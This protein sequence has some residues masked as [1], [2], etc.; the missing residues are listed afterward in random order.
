M[1]PQLDAVLLTG[2]ASTVTRQSDS[3]KAD[4]SAFGTGVDGRGVCLYLC[5]PLVWLSF[6]RPGS[7]QAFPVPWAVSEAYNANCCGQLPP[8]SR[9]W[10]PGLSGRAWGH[11]CSAVGDGLE[12]PCLRQA[13]HTRC[14]L[15]CA[16]LPFGAR[17][18]ASAAFV[19]WAACAWW[20][21]QRVQGRW[22]WARAVH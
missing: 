1:R 6:P 21:C 15:V 8:S 11:P 12:I 19:V 20:G 10:W 14:P 9:C 7:F 2:T 3:G 22:H 5:V 13:R 4:F 18:R 17:G 16:N